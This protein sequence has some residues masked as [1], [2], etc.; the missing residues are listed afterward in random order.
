MGSAT[1]TPGISIDVLKDLTSA[2]SLQAMLSSQEGAVFHVL[3]E[4]E[5]YATQPVKAAAAA[6]ASASVSLIHAASWTTSNG[7]GFSLTPTAKCTV[8]IDTV[9]ETFAIAMNIEST[10]PANAQNVASGPVAGIVWVNIDLDFSIQ[11]AVSGSVTISGIGVAG[12]AAGSAAATLSFC[13]P[14]ADSLNTL[15]AIK[16][17]FQQLV[18]PLDPTCALSMQ[19]GTI[20]KVAFDGTINCELDVTYGL[21]DYQVAAPD[22]TSVQQSLAMS[23]SLRRRRRR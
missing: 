5:A 3:G 10:D 17:A 19:P 13:Q 1:I 18:F 11:G 22:I 4:I 7:V 2:S 12:K 15:D 9:S 16:K 20:A 14:V 8:S 21:G 6:K 23:F